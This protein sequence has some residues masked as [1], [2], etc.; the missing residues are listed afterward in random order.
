[1]TR[2]DTLRGS[3]SPERNFWDVLRYDLHI[4][5][6][7]NSRSIAGYNDI[8]IRWTGEGILMQIDLQPPMEIDSIMP[9]NT[10]GIQS[11]SAVGSIPFYREGNVWHVQ[12]GG[13]RPAALRI[14]FHGRP[15]QARQPPWDGGWIFTQDDL[16]R[17]WMTV[18]CQGLGASVWYPCKDYQGDEPDLGA[19]LSVTVTDSLVAIG[20]G[21]LKTRESHHDGT[22]TW[23]WEVVNP[24]NNYNIVPYI[25]KYVNWTETYSGEKGDLSC[26]YWVLDYHLDK[27]RGQFSQV[28]EMLD[29]F[30]HWFGPFPFYEDGYKLVESPH[31]GMEHQSDI[32]YGNEFT[33]GYLG[34]DL[35]GSGWGLRWD[36]IIIH[37]SAH[38][39]FGNSITSRDIAD[40][41]IHESFANYSESVFTECHD[42]KEAGQAYVT[43]TRDK[44]MNDIPVIGPYGVNREGSGDM[45]CKGGNLIH[46][47][48]Q[49]MDDDEKFRQALRSMSATF[50]H[51]QVTTAEIES[52]WSK[53]AGMDLGP[54]F[55]QYLR[56][57]EIPRIEYRIRKN[58]IS[59]RWARCVEG[60][61][62]PIRVS[63]NGGTP[64]WIHP[65]GEWTK[66]S[67]E[68]KIVSFGI[69]P[70]FYVT[71]SRLP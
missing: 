18:A 45:Y 67:V 5:P 63:L 29:C 31:L 57:T 53:A 3:I 50:Y 59:F 44:I 23:T 10:P 28:P 65:S 17:P 37:E 71:S 58:S 22:T 7:F 36:F 61:N 38:E 70:Q 9:L 4:T 12:T 49:L 15:L 39:W 54:L 55:D 34:T 2:A 33:N 64:Q 19:T 42:G 32:A 69:D 62:L 24:I 66:L 56:T 8:S 48:R 52:Y 43:G 51:A 41:W 40:M 21:K 68:E 46:F 16:D 27:A 47:I 6:D 26:S 11:E 35:S 14:Y 20:N 13:Q 30:E 60:F 1:L 25:G